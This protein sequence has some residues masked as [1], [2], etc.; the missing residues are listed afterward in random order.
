MEV[1]ESPGQIDIEPAAES[2]GE[3]SAT[4]GGKQ[5]SKSARNRRNKRLRNQQKQ[6]D[7]PAQNDAS[8]QEDNGDRKLTQE[9]KNQRRKLYVIFDL[10]A[11][12]VFILKANVSN[13]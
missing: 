2:S 11:L 3:T 10:F 4:N 8:N 6:N 9:E 5:L 12:F 1:A 13:M 7:T